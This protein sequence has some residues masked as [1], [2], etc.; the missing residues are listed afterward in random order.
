MLNDNYRSFCYHQHCFCVISAL[1]IKQQLQSF[2]FHLSWL[3]FLLLALERR[4]PPMGPHRQLNGSLSEADI[5]VWIGSEPSTGHWLQAIYPHLHPGIKD[6]V[7][8][9]QKLL[10][11]KQQLSFPVA[12]AL[13]L[14]VQAVCCGYLVWHVDHVH[15]P[16]QLHRWNTRILRQCL[17]QT[18]EILRRLLYF[19]L[20]H[21][22]SSMTSA[23]WN[24][25]IWMFFFIVNLTRISSWHTFATV[26][27]LSV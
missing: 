1:H 8:V 9:K 13:V 3:W 7:P 22:L 20:S 14:P 26:L 16:A 17:N 4:S 25:T 11:W 10:Q 18:S 23:Q 19:L 6:K 15:I 21:S 24:C 12:S 5:C 27:V 2:S